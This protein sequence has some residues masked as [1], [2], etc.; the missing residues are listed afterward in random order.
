MIILFVSA[1]AEVS[2]SVVTEV[3]TQVCKK[4]VFIC[5]IDDDSYFQ[6][7][8]RTKKEKKVNQCYTTKD[9]QTIAVEIL[10]Y[11]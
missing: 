5:I 9:F 1:V 6:L 8:C 10:A 2:T 4:V 7:L 3:T 11:F